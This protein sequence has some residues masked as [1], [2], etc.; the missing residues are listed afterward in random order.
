MNQ[1]IDVEYTTISATDSVC[2]EMPN[3][4]PEGKLIDLIDLLDSKAEIHISNDEF[5]TAVFGDSRGEVRP[6]VCA[7]EGNPREVGKA[8]WFGKPWINGK[9]QFYSPSNNYFSLASFSPN[10]DD[11][12]YRRQ[13]KNF[14]A[15]HAVALDDIGTKAKALDRLTIPPSWLL[16]TSPGN[17]QA[18]YIFKE[19][20]VDGLSVGKLMKAIIAANLCDG[21]CDGPMAR[22]VRLPSGAN[23][24]HTP[25]YDCRLI[26]WNPEC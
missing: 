2:V 16:E 17:Y 8:A 3:L 14:V 10:A 25:R 5:L 20:V 26:K 18:G 7:F 24:K 15:S 13:K 4:L 11:G 12:K 21:G 1:C 9:V 22:M 6:I 23:W 19:P